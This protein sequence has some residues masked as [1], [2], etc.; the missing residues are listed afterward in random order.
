MH[1]IQIVWNSP[2]VTAGFMESFM[3]RVW[4]HQEWCHNWHDASPSS[5]HAVFRQSLLRETNSLLEVARE[6][7]I[8]HSTLLETFHVFPVVLINGISLDLHACVQ[9]ARIKELSEAIESAIQALKHTRTR[10]G[11]K[12]FQKIRLVLEEALS[13]NK[14]HVRE[15]LEYLNRH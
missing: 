2:K 3:S 5:E 8:V 13:R 14:D 9:E 6:I 10:L 12:S 7:S 1:S 4:H 11:N 15:V